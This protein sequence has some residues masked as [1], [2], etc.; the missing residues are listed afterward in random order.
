MIGRWSGLALWVAVGALVVNTAAGAQT[1]TSEQTEPT[2]TGGTTSTAPAT[3]NATCPV[4]TDEEVDPNFWAEYKGQRI[5]FCCKR[6]RT[7]FE[8]DPDAYVAN[9]ASFTAGAKVIG[10]AQTGSADGEGHAD[11]HDESNAG[12]EPA[13]EHGA[14]EGD[15]AEPAGEAD[16]DHDHDKDHGQTSSFK[17]LPFI[18]RFHMLVIHFPIALLLVG[19]FMETISIV[20]K[21]G[22]GTE[23]VVR[24][25][26]GFGAVAAVVAVL[27]GLANAIGADYRGTLSWVFWWHR[28]LGIT[29]A[30]VALVA[31][32]AVERRARRATPA[33]IASAR[34]LLF[35]AALLVGVTGHFGGSLVYGWDYL[36][37]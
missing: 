29:T 22:R 12:G 19:A 17:L 24:V 18:G 5:G 35:L 3:V 9:L 32:I 8:A 13:H 25:T 26:V 37:P 27:L 4:T 2:D 36:L 11:G 20:K 10:V 14:G 6:C 7:K 23:T 28:A 1:G 31:W 34:V 21:G 30:T 15:S 33:S 16:H